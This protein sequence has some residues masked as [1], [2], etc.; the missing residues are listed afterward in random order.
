MSRPMRGAEC[1]G[2][3]GNQKRRLGGKSQ[4]TEG[5]AE[6]ANGGIRMHDAIGAAGARNTARAFKFAAAGGLAG[7]AGG[8]PVLI[9]FVFS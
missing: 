3:S 4:N 2:T 7:D 6:R 9:H 8:S 5:E 1:M